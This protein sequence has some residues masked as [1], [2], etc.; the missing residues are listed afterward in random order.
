MTGASSSKTSVTSIGDNIAANQVMIGRA[1][2]GRVKQSRAVFVTG[3]SGSS[4]S[5]VVRA[6]LI[7]ALKH[8]AIPGN[9]HWLYE[10]MKPGRSPRC[11]RYAWAMLNQAAVE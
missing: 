4:K 6:G 3:P 2:V 1:V 9:D 5:S 7:P 10:A 11:R 8:G